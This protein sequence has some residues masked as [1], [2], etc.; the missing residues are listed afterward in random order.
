MGTQGRDPGCRGLLFRGALFR[1]GVCPISWVPP[2]F[3]R[4]RRRGPLANSRRA[5]GAHGFVQLVKSGAGQEVGKRTIAGGWGA[6]EG[7]HPRQGQMGGGF[8][9]PANCPSRWGP[10]PGETRGRRGS[11]A[12]SRERRED[13]GNRVGSKWSLDTGRRDRRFVYG[14]LM[15][16]KL[17]ED[18]GWDG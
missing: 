12:D 2:I 11:R 14:G 18:T 6:D 16:D 1:Y 15:L 17:G 8:A 7:T 4:G 13:V 9:G 5:F 3:V 10:T